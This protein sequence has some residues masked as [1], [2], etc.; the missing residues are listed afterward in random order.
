MSYTEKAVNVRVAKN[1]VGFTLHTLREQPLGV[2]KLLWHLQNLELTSSNV[3][4]LYI[5]I[6]KGV[7]APAQPAEY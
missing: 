4:P 6:E 7:S 3:E 5:T 1:L 2:K